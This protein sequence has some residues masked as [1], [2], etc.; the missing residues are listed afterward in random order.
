M[1]TGALHLGRSLAVRTWLVG[2][3]CRR[4]LRLKRISLVRHEI[5]NF[6]LPERLLL[7]LLLLRGLLGEL[8]SVVGHW[9]VEE[10][11]FALGWIRREWREDLGVLEPGVGLGWRSGLAERV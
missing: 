10:R 6:G 7:L 3:E 4:C 5:V 8:I 9:R 2:L 11:D 1:A